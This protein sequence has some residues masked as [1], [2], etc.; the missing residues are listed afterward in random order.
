MFPIA[1]RGSLTTRDAIEDPDIPL[2]IRV[3]ISAVSAFNDL[4]ATHS[5]SSPATADQETDS[6]HFSREYDRPHSRNLHMFE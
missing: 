6:V 4:I 1:Y 3:G 2:N 5:M